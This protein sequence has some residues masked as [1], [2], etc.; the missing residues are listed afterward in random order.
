MYVWRRRDID[1][2][3]LVDVYGTSAVGDGGGDAR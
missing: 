1:V 3:R 2:D